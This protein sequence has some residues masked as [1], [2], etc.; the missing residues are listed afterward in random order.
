MQTQF[1]KLQVKKKK[2][3]EEN[4]EE[5][6]RRKRLEMFNFLPVPLGSSGRQ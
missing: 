4:I 1:E 6:K 5:E 3:R 2:R